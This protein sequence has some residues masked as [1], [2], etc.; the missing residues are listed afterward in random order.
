MEITAILLDMLQWK[1][2]LIMKNKSILYFPIS[3]FCVV[4]IGCSA[5]GPYKEFSGIVNQLRKG[6][7]QDEVKAIAGEP[8]FEGYR[9]HGRLN[10][11]LW[12]YSYREITL[13]QSVHLTVYF[14]DK[15]GTVVDWEEWAP[16]LNP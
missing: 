6:M 11:Q 7:T 8:T 2:P 13:W 14:S 5:T 15:N 10:K 9:M 1:E 4:I 3:L 12:M 16:A